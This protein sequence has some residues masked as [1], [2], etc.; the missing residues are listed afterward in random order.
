MSWQETPSQCRRVD[1]HTFNN[2][3]GVFY[4]ELY[5]MNGLVLKV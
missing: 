1:S 2:D 4:S 5:L 3:D